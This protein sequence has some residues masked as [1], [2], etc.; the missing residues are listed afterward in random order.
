MTQT[1][2]NLPAVQEPQVQSLGLKD[3]LEKGMATRSSILAWR[4]PWTEEP[5]ELQ[6][7]E[8]QKV[9]HI[10]ATNTFIFFTFTII[11]NRA[12]RVQAFPPQQPSLSMKIQEADDSVSHDGDKE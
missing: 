10:W 6:S 7:L 11:K 2:K 12:G 3:P 8:L 1:I 5:G 9:R 4:I